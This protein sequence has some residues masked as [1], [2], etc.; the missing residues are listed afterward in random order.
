MTSCG[1]HLARVHLSVYYSSVNTYQKHVKLCPLKV[2]NDVQLAIAKFCLSIK[3]FQ[4]RP[5]LN[6]FTTKGMG[7]KILA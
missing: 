1:R 5:L 4:A 6:D 7:P 2:Q 3:D